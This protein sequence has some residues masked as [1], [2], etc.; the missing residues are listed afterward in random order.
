MSK[1]GKITQKFQDAYVAEDDFWKI[2]NYA[3]E[4]DRLGKAYAKAGIKRTA[5]EL[6]EEAADI[7]R[8]TVPNYAYVSDTVRALR[9]SPVGNFM[10]FPSE[11]M[12]TGTNIVRRSLREMRDSQEY[13][14]LPTPANAIFIC[15]TI[16]FTYNL[17]YRSI[18]ELDSKIFKWLND[19]LSNLKTG[20]RND[21]VIL[22]SLL[23]D[24]GYHTH[25]DN[26]VKDSLVEPREN[27][28]SPVEMS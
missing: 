9:V 3:V 21:F 24:I 13:L 11:I 16:L 7:V 22:L 2:T 6:K 1:L 23:M 25:K 12:R 20:I 27:R 5:R 28:A 14:G 18:I 19:F 17:P 10:S 15:S 4:M 26:L 8:N